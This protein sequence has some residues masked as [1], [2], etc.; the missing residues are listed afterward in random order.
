MFAFVRRPLKTG[1]IGCA[2]QGAQCAFALVERPAGQRPVLRWTVRADWSRPVE[3]LRRL[4]RSHAL[5]RHPRVA[6]LQPGQYQ[7]IGLDAP[8]DVP[9]ED[10]GAALRWQLKD[11]VDFAVDDAAIDLLALPEGTAHRAQPQVIVVAAPAAQVQPLML[12][13]RDA[14]APWH[15][16]DV[17]ETALRNLSALCEPDGRAQALLHCQA[18]HATLAVTYRRELLSTRRVDIAID[19]LTDAREGVRQNA[20]DHLVLELQRTLDGFERAFGLVSL[21]RLLVA[22]MPA[23]QR[24]IDALRPL[25]YVPVEPLELADLV[26]LSAAPELAGDEIEQNRQLSAIGAALRDDAAHAR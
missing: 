12:L 17:G 20:F 1:W 15:A 4:Q 5:R 14:G 26:D 6:L 21:A 16:I 10:W 7:C 2:P 25:V 3:A 22:P 19:Q 13:A 23:R 24:F 8:A 18:Q 11:S 9:R